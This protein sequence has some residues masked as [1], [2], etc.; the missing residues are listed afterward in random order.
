[1]AAVAAIVARMSVDAFR[2]KNLFD[3]A[4]TMLAHVR[5]CVCVHMCALEFV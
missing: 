4:I 3:L 2:Y 5:A 1:M